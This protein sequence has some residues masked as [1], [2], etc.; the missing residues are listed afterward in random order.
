MDAA[1]LE[2]RLTER[3][4]LEFEENGFFVVKDV[5]SPQMVEDLIPVVDRLDAQ[6]RA[7][8]GLGP[9]DRVNMLDF[10]GKDDLFLELLDWPRIF[11][12]VWDILGI[13]LQQLLAKSIENTWPVLNTR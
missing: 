3:E 9:H 11:P 12:K 5:L 1:C 6:Y 13:H 8:R 2:H 7:E 4:R 10:I